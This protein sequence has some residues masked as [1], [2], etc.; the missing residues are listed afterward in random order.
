MLK[1]ETVGFK[2]KTIFFNIS[3]LLQQWC[4]NFNYSEVSIKKQ[5][6]MLK[7]MT[8]V[9]IPFQKGDISCM[10]E[11]RQYILLLKIMLR[12]RISSS[13]G[14]SCTTNNN[15]CYLARVISSA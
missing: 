13:F 14:A 8:Y 7:G 11:N 3:L 10:F 4:F 12:V 1:V 2:K 15:K 5:N 9:L 6:I